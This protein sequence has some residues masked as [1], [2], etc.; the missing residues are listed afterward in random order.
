[1]STHTTPNRES[2]QAAART[3]ITTLAEATDPQHLLQHSRPL[4]TAV[5][6]M[7]AKLT[8]PTPTHRDR[9]RTLES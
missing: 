3:V 5:K 6:E 7:E 2:L 9:R 8:A 1:M 4:H